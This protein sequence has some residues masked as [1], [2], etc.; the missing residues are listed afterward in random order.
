M[1]ISL[2]TFSGPGGSPDLKLVKFMCPKM[3]EGSAYLMF[4]CIVCH[5]KWLRLPTIGEEKTIA[6]PFHPLNVISKHGNDTRNAN[7]CRHV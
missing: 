6:A 1:R 4:E 2:E 7:G 5:L 3:K